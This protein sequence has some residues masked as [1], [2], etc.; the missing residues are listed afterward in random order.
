MKNVVRL[1]QGHRFWIMW[2]AA[3]LILAWYAITDPDHGLETLSRIQWLLW[4]IVAA[5]PIY[6]LRRAFHPEAR[7]GEA[8]RKAME[9]P[10]GAGLV[11]L[12]LSILTGFLFL[13]FSGQARAEGLPAG[14]V[15]Y[16]PVLNAEQQRFWADVPLRSALAAQIEQETCV[17]PSSPK[18]WNPRT[19]LKTSRE[20]GFGLGQL[21]VT[22]RFNNFEQAKKLDESLRGWKFEERFDPARQLRA[23]VLMDRESF[24]RLSFVDDPIERQ[25]MAFSAYNGGLSGVLTDRRL[26]AQKPGCD[27]SKWF[28]HVEKYS[29]K[30][31]VKAQGYGQSF[32]DINRG[33]VRSV[34]YSRRAKYAPFF[35]ET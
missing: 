18:C 23:M 10:T 28:D 27:P 29:L 33:Y 7:S 12:G 5:G 11:F 24:R 34:M 21:T 35:R 30:A 31:K 15:T 8:Y 6:L 32:F 17:R 1:F 16:L 26:C 25:A 22:P 14:A 2:A 13:A 3:A 19:E 9:S 20:Y 4:P